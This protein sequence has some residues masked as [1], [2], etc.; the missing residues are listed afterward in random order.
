MLLALTVERYIS[1]CFPARARNMC[2]AE[3]RA[4]VTVIMLPVVTF[5]LYSPYLFL[6][7]VHKCLDGKGKFHV[8]L[9]ACSKQRRISQGVK[10]PSVLFFAYDTVIILPV[11]TFALYSP[12]LFLAGVHKCLDGKGKFQLFMLFHRH[13]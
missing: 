4:Y 8:I 3:R 11:V 6:A 12:Y 5:A 13:S 10:A 1:V 7:G 2:G 9:S